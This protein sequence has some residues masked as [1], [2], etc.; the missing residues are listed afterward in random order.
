MTLSGTD[1]ARYRDTLSKINKKAI[2]ELDKFIEKLGGYVGNEYEVV[3]Y[4]YALATKY[5][6][7][8]A[9]M[10]CMMY[11]AMA[12]AEKVAVLPAV[13]AATASVSEVSRAVR[14]AGDISP[15]LVSPAVGRLVKQ[16]AADTTLQ[17]AQRDGAQFA[18]IPSGDTCAYCLS[19]A[20]RGWQYISKNAQASHAEHIHNNCDCQ[21]MVR[22]HESTKVAGYDPGRYKKMYDS[23]DGR[24]SKD[25]INALRREAYAEDKERINE[26]KRANYAARRAEES[27]LIEDV[28]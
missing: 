27:E 15:K 6:E 25:K 8:A 19:I 22:F 21:F 2:D 5:G 7:A 1:W 10:A 28:D 18:W 20:S 11:D 24:T 23:A 9:E 13:P 3:E 14:G 4:A 26:M 17:N 12:A 16:A